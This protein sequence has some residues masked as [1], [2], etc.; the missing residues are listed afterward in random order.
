MSLKHTI[1]R[2]YDIRGL[3]HVD[4][5]LSPDN[6]RRIVN[7]Y[8]ASKPTQR[9]L[10]IGSDHRSS[11]D[12]F[13]EI[14]AAAA[15]DAGREVV[16]IGTVTTPMFYFAQYSLHIPVG[17]MITASRS[18]A[19]WN[20]FM[21]ADGY[22]STLVGDAIQHIRDLAAA[23]TLPER[24]GKGSVRTADIREDYIQAITC[25]LR[26][27]ETRF[28]LVIDCGNGTAGSVAPD[29][30]ERL[31]M[32]V[33]PLYCEPDFS[34]PNH[35]PN[36]S[37]VAARAAA[38]AAVCAHDA[39]LAL[40]FDG[41][42]DR[43]GVIDNRGEDVWSDQVLLLLSLR[44]LEKGQSATVVF[45]VNSTQAL[46][47][48]LLARGGVPIM[49]KTGQ[50][51]IRQKSMEAGADLAGDRSGHILI[52]DRWFGFDDPLFA[53]ACLLEELSHGDVSLNDRMLQLPRYLASPEI[54]AHCADDVKYD[55]VQRLTRDFKRDFDKV[56]DIDGARVVFPDG[57]GVVRA[58]SDVPELVFIFEARSEERLREIYRIFRERCELCPEI[59]RQWRNDMNATNQATE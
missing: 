31:G 53:G 19:E 3:A 52:F 41:D 8:L 59:G 37:D 57:W 47:E 55:V 44:L 4:D 10:I 54:R 6:V 23:N 14:A 13:R 28:K 33:V 39:D 16:D 34:F 48:L 32:D 24:L 36:P 15:M 40:L 27:G 9:S 21:L 50:P 5:E 51:Y 2:E 56:I 35:S 12:E 1:F 29:V 20:G 22:S 25:R 43:L 49:W 30:F 46:E 42:G 7:A 38:R 18:A 26:L 58:S 11:S 45:D 17:I